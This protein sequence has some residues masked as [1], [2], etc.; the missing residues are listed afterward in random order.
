M[1]TLKIKN[2]ANSFVLIVVKLVIIT[3]KQAHTHTHSF[4]CYTYACLNSILNI[5]SF[6]REAH[7]YNENV[8]KNESIIKD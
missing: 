2:H 4:Y 1:L 7:E 6:Q 5:V 8:L 3:H